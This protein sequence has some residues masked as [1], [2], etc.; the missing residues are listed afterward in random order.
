MILAV[1]PFTVIDWIVPE[2]VV[3]VKSFNTA[4]PFAVVATT[5]NVTTGR[6]EPPG[7]YCAARE[8]E[9]TLVIEPIVDVPTV[10]VDPGCKLVVVDKFD[11]EPEYVNC[12]EGVTVCALALPKSA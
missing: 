7:I 9:S 12:I 11:V 2:T 5:L 1:C 8:D 6:V 3:N 4:P 10:V